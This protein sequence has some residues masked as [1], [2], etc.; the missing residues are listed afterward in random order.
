MSSPS[1]IKVTV[2]YL[3]TAAQGD[4][5]TIECDSFEERDGWVQ[6]VRGKKVRMLI[7]KTSIM[8]MELEY[9]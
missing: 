3:L 1:K 5:T 9:E 7:N 8:D 4:F 6:F 2:R